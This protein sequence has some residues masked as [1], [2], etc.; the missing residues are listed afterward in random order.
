[1]CEAIADAGFVIEALW[2]QVPCRRP[3]NVTPEQDGTVAE[4]ALP[5]GAWPGA[6]QVQL[7]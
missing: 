7:C 5:G 2:N 4:F 3:P 6:N 1:M